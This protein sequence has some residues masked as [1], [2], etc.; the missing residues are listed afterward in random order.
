MHFT[1]NERKL[2]H[3]LELKEIFQVPKTV[4]L[5]CVQETGLAAYLPPES[6]SRAQ[7]VHNKH[8]PLPSVLVSDATQHITAE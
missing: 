8:A 5:L 4:T 1:L 7:H 3:T 2:K 6:F